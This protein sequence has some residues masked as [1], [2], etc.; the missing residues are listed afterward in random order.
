MKSVNIGLLLLVAFLLGTIACMTVQQIIVPPARAGSAATNWE[1]TC[2]RFS[3]FD[4]EE[5][6]K[7]NEFGSQGW[8]LAAAHGP[9][10]VC[11]KRPISPP[12]IPPGDLSTD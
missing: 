8:E 7:M 3:T 4:S 2:A 10:M 1:Y 5:I 6:T 9:N 12:D 11:F